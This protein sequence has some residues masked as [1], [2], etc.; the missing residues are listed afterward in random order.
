M[1]LH[2]ISIFC[3][4]SF[5]LAGATAPLALA[6]PIEYQV[7]VDTTSIL[8]TYGYIDMQFNAGLT[9][10]Q[11]ATATVSNFVTDGVLNPSD[12]NN[13][14]SGNVTGSLPTSVMF[15]NGTTL[16][17]YTEGLTF[18]TTITFD[19]TLDGQ[20]IESPNGSGGGTT[21]Y[22]DFL[23]SSGNYLLTN[24]PSGFVGYVTINPNGTTTATENP[25]P[26][27]GASVVTFTPLTPTPSVPEPATLLLLSGGLIGVG[28][29]ARRRR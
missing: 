11:S 15:N 17:E 6:S 10:T 28:V 7:T 5:L 4:C 14:T 23:D 24:D 29:F 26:T 18:G 25:G 19:L 22:L 27:G 9:T 3:A 1:K 8:L 20:M 2:T 21:F 12:P 13:G 16:N